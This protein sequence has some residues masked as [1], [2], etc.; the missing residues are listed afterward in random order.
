MQGEFAARTKRRAL[1]KISRPHVREILAR[2]RLYA[3]LDAARVHPVTWIMGP[4]GSGKTTLVASFLDARKLPCVWYQVDEGDN[5]IATFFYY[6]GLADQQANPRKQKPLP[7]FS[8]EY[9]HGVPTFARNFFSEL[10]ERLPR[11]AALVFDNYH[12][13]GSDSKLHEVM[14]AGLEAIPARCQVIAISRQS[15]PPAL[16]RLQANR[17]MAVIGW[18]DLQLSETEARAIVVLREPELGAIISFKPWVAR[19]QGWVAGLV[20]L[21]EWLR[22]EEVEPEGLATFAPESIFD[23]FAGELLERL[24]PEAQAFLLKS[25]ILPKM[26]PSMTA[27]LTGEAHAERIL[28][29]LHRRNLFITRHTNADK[30]YQYHPLLREFL[31]AQLEE[32]VPPE[33]LIA[34]K[35]QGAA[36]LEGEGRIESAIELLRETQD[37]SRMT[38]FIKSSAP[39]MLAQSRSAT[40]EEWIRALPENV[41]ASDAWITY[42]WG[43]SIL[44][45]RPAHSLRCFEMAFDK[46]HMAG[47]ASGLYLAWCGVMEAIQYDRS[48]SYKRWDPWMER[49]EALLQTNAE[50]PSMEIECRV[51]Q[52]M[53][54]ALEFRNPT[55]PRRPWWRERMLELT[56]A[57]GNTSLQADTL[58]RTTLADAHRDLARAGTTAGALRQLMKSGEISPLAMAIGYT[59]LAVYYCACGRIADSVDSASKGVTLAEKTGIHTWD[60]MCHVWMTVG[61][62]GKSDLQKGREMLAQVANRPEARGTVGGHYYH[63]LAAWAALLEEDYAEAVAH[64]RECVRTGNECGDQRLRPWGRATLAWALCAQGHTKEA[65]T[66]ADEALEL[67]RRGGTHWVEWDCLLV[68]AYAAFR[69]GDDMLGHRKLEEVFGLGRS[70]GY[71]GAP[72]C[73]GYAITLL[74]IRALAAG[75][76]TAYARDLARIW[77]PSSERPPLELE[78]WPWAVKVYT[79][80]RFEILRDDRPLA[81]SRKAPKKPLQLLKAIVAAGGRGVGE[82]QLTDALWPEQ[83][84]D[85][86]H[87]A[88]ASALHR[89]RQLLGEATVS[90]VEGRVNLDLRRVWVDSW[91]F[92]SLAVQAETAPSAGSPDTWVSS[93]EQA[94]SLYS[95]NFLADELESA[96]AEVPR[97]RLRTRFIRLVQALAAHFEQA[98]DWTAA[99]SAYEHGLEI[100]DLAESLYQGL[101]RCHHQLGHRAEALDAYYRC[102]LRLSI[103]LSAK[104]SA[105]TEAI[106]KTVQQ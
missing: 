47:D 53:N 6:L 87:H 39:A 62:L 79:L 51:A 28:A 43:Q 31:L 68:Q 32:T 106:L 13:A 16:A 27:I 8:F 103:C 93:A 54:M 20:L 3:K 96:W 101:M 77:G 1:A 34:L 94:V 5:D 56:A 104:P 42:W 86:A 63:Q 14:R 45:V 69:A 33:E 49:L 105:A 78:N 100:D 7:L 90:L 58:A 92:E 60:Y 29:D 21:L 2:E 71:F 38:E 35:R 10:C 25:A 55:H 91:T 67:A 97:H 24:K 48:G 66:V 30:V 12:E 95:G 83:E 73:P 40:L 4:A 52:R 76:E 37:W 70:H 61:A 15:P 46:F 22:T 99:L 57:T 9:A 102:K 64:A 82:A 74:C 36:L 19:L 80:G 17:A 72:A 44:A 50:F 75:I 11:P 88:F 81:F 65:K 84:G 26:T 89:L 98:G 41:R 59:A 18:K 23:Y 85:A